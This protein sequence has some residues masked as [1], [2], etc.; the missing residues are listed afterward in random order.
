[1]DSAN[2]YI[3]EFLTGKTKIPEKERLRYARLLLDMGQLKMAGEIL[4]KTPST[5][6][7]FYKSEY[8]FTRGRLLEKEMQRSDAILSYVKSL[9]ANP[10]NLQAS[11]RLKSQYI[12]AGEKKKAE[13]VER[14]LNEKRKRL[15]SI[16]G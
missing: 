13:L 8:D 14:D 12:L 15:M 6:S 9:Q 3:T 7:A 16:K 11:K 2:Y 4:A 10:Y 5:G 1:M